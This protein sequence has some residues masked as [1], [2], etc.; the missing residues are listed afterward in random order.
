MNKTFLCGF[1]TLVSAMTLST[2]GFAEYKPSPAPLMTVWGEEMTPETAW[3]LHPRPNLERSN[4]QNLNGLWDYAVTPINAPKQPKVWE[5]KVLVPFAMES[6]L[7]GVGRMI[8]PNEAVWYHRTFDVSSLNDERLLLH[9]D[10]V[11]FRSQ[12]FVNGMEVTDYPHESGI[13]PQTVDVTKVVKEGT[14]DLLVYVWDPTDT[15]QNATGKQ[16]LKPGGIMYT[17]TSG[18][19]QP[20]W[21]ETVP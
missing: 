9:F 13:I 14:N 12:V 19:W 20:V 3:A 21:M 4:W 5:G 7:S 10:G 1:C 8:E 11:D 2:V 16:V 18:I 15:W 17:R 6:A